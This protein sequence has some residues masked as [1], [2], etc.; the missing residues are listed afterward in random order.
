MPR[1]CPQRQEGHTGG[2]QTESRSVG[3][4]AHQL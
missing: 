1:S 2:I 3:K 4:R